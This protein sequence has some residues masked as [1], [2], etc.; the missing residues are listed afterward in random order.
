MRPEAKLREAPSAPAIVKKQFVRV[1]AGDAARA[2]RGPLP[3]RGAPARAC[4]KEV[5]L[6]QLDGRV[7][8]L[9]VTCSCGEVT[10]VELEFPGRTDP[11]D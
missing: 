11:T 10:V 7:R 8:G 4:S 2:V 9:E 5:R 6:L 3:A 1:D